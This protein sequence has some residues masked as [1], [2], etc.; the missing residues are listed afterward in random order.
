MQIKAARRRPT[1]NLFMEWELIHT[2]PF[3]RDLEIAVIDKDGS[4]ALAFPSRRILG[5]W[6]NAE[7]KQRI[8]VRP[9]HWRAW[10]A[11]SYA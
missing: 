3:D 11:A 6:V 10:P 7:T 2:A 8:E 4:H 1:A 9:T 5:G